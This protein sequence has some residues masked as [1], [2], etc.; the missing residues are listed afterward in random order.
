M[1]RGAWWAA[2]HEVAELDTTELLNTYRLGRYPGEGNGYTLQFSCLENPMDRGAWHAIIVHG[3]IK[4]QTKLR[5]NTFTSNILTFI[6]VPHS[7]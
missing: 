3:V 2:G 1:D 7:K 4:S 6:I 5:T